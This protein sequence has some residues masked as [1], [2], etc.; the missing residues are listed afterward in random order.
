MMGLL[1]GIQK[2]GRTEKD[3]LEELSRKNKES[4]PKEKIKMQDKEV[5]FPESIPKIPTQVKGGNV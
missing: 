1:E 3:L 4:A 2:Y 5:I